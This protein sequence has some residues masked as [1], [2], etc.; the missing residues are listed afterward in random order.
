MKNEAKKNVQPLEEASRAP[1]VELHREISG[2]STAAH[3]FR[4]QEIS[5]PWSYP[6]TMWMQREEVYREF[7]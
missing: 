7:F 5:S 4:K 3:I 2:S 1:P 6:L